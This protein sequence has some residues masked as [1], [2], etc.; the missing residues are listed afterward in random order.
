MKK[1]SW[2]ILFVLICARIGH[3][4]QA[5]PSPF[6]ECA[7]TP[8]GTNRVLLTWDADSAVEGDYFVIERSPDET[9]YE[10]ISVVR[11]AAGM[12]HYEVVDAG[13]PNGSDF[14]RIKYT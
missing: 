1:L 3:A 7:A 9:H 11:V 4:Q 10:T 5:N 13:A 6:V 8:E 14:Y 12:R 2:L